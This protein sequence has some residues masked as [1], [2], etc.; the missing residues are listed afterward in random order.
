MITPFFNQ[1]MPLIR[2]AIGDVA[3]RGADSSSCACGCSFKPLEHLEG[4]IQDL[5]ILP[6]GR[7]LVSTFFPQA[8]KEF[9]VRQFQVLQPDVA[10]L[11]IKIVPGSG[12]D[13]Q[14]AESPEAPDCGI[15]PRPSSVL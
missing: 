9:D 1:G 2:Y 8:F 12:F 11:R 6:G 7:F 10:T 5:I 14:Q 3:V 4:R 13:A 15:Y